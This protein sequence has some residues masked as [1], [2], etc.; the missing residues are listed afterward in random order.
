[1]RKWFLAL[2]ALFLVPTTT[3][4]GATIHV[5][6]DQLTIQAGLD[7]AGAGDTV[8]VA[9]GTYYE[10]DL[11]MKPGVCLT[12]ATGLADCVTVDAQGQGRVLYC[13]DVDS[14]AA[15]VGLMITGGVAALSSPAHGGG[16]MY[17]DH[18]SPVLSD[19][20]FR[21]NSGGQ[22]GGLYLCDESSPALQ[23]CTFSC[24]HSNH[25]GGIYCF[26]FCRPVLNDCVFNDNSADNDGGGIYC[27]GGNHL[28]LL[29]CTF[30]GNT[31]SNGGG[32]FSNTSSATLE[33]CVLTAN[34][35]HGGSGG[36]VLVMNNS[37]FEFDGSGFSAN[38]AQSSGGAVCC[39]FALAEFDGCSLSDNGAPSGG[40]LWCG[41][42]CPS[43][44]LDRTI[45]A[46]STQGASL[47]CDDEQSIPV[48]TCCDVYG[49]EGG[50]WVPWIA[51]QC[52][53]DGNI[54]S[55]PLFCRETNPDV[56]YALHADSPCAPGANPECGLIGAWG[57]GCEATAATVTSWG[58]LKGMFR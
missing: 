2:L 13:S 51:D 19:C 54:S 53:V 15:I 4:Y 32:I 41:W 25:G 31:A 43:V 55:D 38:T 34:S 52:G 36:A 8:L 47:C 20:V 24:N 39:L 11:I 42:H 48:L 1:M 29:G 50:D 46:F 14:T 49:N 57:I 27:T 7:A 3:A 37:W 16:G 28:S 5:P 17:C 35:A 10:H 18:S 12:S 56:P 30:V 58:C 6:G 44:E 45:I 9:C 21:S 33:D 26:Y 23:R 22:G 40:G